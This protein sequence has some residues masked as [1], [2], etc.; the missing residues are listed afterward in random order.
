MHIISKRK[1]ADFWKRYPKARVSMEAWFRIMSRGNFSSFNELKKT[2]ASADY[3]DGL[4]VFDIGG[5]NFRLIAA[6]HFNRGKVY[7]RDVL[8][9]AAY[10]RNEWKRE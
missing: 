1:L 5:N 9:H 2:F 10:D 3:V 4:I 6:I 8:T 7:V